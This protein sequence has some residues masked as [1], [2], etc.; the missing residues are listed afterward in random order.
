MAAGEFV[1]FQVQYNLIIH[2]FSS[3]ANDVPAVLDKIWMS[4]ARE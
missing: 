4:G 2:R 1:V 3:L